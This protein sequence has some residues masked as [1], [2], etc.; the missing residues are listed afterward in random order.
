ME[1]TV[2]EWGE[3]REDTNQIIIQNIQLE[4]GKKIS[5]R[6]VQKATRDYMRGK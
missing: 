1:P 6:N 4:T 3:E 5:E 2:W